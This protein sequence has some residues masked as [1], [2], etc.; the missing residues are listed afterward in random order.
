MDEKIFYKGAEISEKYK[1]NKGYFFTQELFE[2]DFKNRAPITLREKIDKES[3]EALEI[4]LSGY[5]GCPTNSKIV[6]KTYKH[7]KKTLEEVGI[8]IKL[9]YK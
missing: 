3:V 9:F 7:F 5:Y 4:N 2:G 8:N 1:K 6:F